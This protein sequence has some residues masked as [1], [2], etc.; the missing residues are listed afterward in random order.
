MASTEV[1]VLVS[2]I[3]LALLGANKLSS[4]LTS[5][6]IELLIHFPYFWRPGTLASTPAFVLVLVVCLIFNMRL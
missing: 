3:E 1:D 5:L 2:Y 6:I 4:F